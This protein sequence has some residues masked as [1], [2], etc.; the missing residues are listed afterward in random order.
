[1]VEE[2]KGFQEIPRKRRY[3]YLRGASLIVMTVLIITFLVSGMAFGIQSLIR[4]GGEEVARGVWVDG[5]REFRILASQWNFEPGIIKVNPGDT[6]RFRVTSTD[7]MHGFTINELNINLYLP[8]GVEVVHEVVI[9][10]DIAEGIYRIDCNICGAIGHPPMNGS[11][12]IGSYSVGMGENLPYI[13]SPLLWQAYSPLLSSE[14]VAQ[15]EM[16]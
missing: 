2:E 15:D 8:S 7:L 3:H 13:S 12:I 16:D 6:V 10:S 5:V 4:D 14:G 1:M 9:P 11:I